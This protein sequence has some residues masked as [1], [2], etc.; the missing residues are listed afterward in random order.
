MA[1]VQVVVR[2]VVVV[3]VLAGLGPAELDLDPARRPARAHGTCRG[4]GGRFFAPGLPFASTAR[5]TP[6]SST[7]VIRPVTSSAPPAGPTATVTS[8]PTLR[9]QC[10]CSV[11]G[12]STPGL[13]TSST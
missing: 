6:A 13:V 8:R 10:R 1:V 12:R 7:A 5:V 9:R 11:S 2:L 4:V 3:A